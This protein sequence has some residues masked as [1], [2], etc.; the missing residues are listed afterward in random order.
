MSGKKNPNIIQYYPNISTGK[1]ELYF[2]TV[3]VF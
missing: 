3:I 2:V 1:T